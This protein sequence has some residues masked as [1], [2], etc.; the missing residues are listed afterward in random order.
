MTRR[1]VSV[2]GV[3]VEEAR[4]TRAERL[5]LIVGVEDVFGSATDVVN[6]DDRTIIF[7]PLALLK[8]VVFFCKASAEGNA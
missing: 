3:G 8:H 2:G 6:V 7:P 5:L 1:R 4:V